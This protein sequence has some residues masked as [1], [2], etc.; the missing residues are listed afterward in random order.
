MKIQQCPFCRQHFLNKWG[1]IIMLNFLLQPYWYFF[2]PYA[3][4][5][6]IL[7][8]IT[9]CFLLEWLIELLHR[10]N[11]ADCMNERN[12]SNS[13]ET[14]NAEENRR[15]LLIRLKQRFQ[16]NKAQRILISQNSLCLMKMWWNTDQILN[17]THHP[18]IQMYC[19]IYKKP[20]NDLNIKIM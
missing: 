9:I 11:C 5:Y 12:I 20:I 3:M 17:L 6:L 19:R 10:V 15:K 1:K 2:I 7:T 18:N 13:S 8:L 16:E 14:E 4:M